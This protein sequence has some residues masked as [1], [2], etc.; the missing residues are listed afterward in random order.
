VGPEVVLEGRAEDDVALVVTKQIK[1][2]FIGAG[3]GQ[4]EVIERIAVRGDSRRIGD[5]VRVLPGGRLGLQEGAQ[6][7]AVYQ[8]PDAASFKISFSSVRSETGFRSRAFSC[9]RSFSRFT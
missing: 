4:V 9:S 8:F 1:L 7:L 2:H 6:G 5:T 3:P